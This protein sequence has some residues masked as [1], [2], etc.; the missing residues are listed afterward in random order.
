[1]INIA[2]LLARSS[3][4]PMPFAPR[5]ILAQNARTDLQTLARAHSTPQS[6]GLRARIVLKAADTDTPTNRQIGRDLG[7]S[8]HTVGKWRRRYLALGFSGLQDALRPGRPRTIASPTRVKVISVASELPQDQ[9]RTVTRWTLDEIVTTLLDALHTDAISRS[10]IWRI[11][12]DI[13]LKPHKSAYWLNS[14]DEHFD[15]KAHTICQL[16]AQALES[17][18][19]GRLVI[20]CDEKTGM[21]VLERKAPTKPAQPGR[22]ERREHEYI[23]HGTRVLINS[24]AVATGQLAWTMGATRKTTDFVVHLKQAYQSLPRMQCYDWVMD[25]LNTHW[26]LDVCCLV[27]RWCQV[28]FE[29]HKLKKGVQRRAFLSDPSHRHVFHFTPKHGS[30]LNQAELFFGVLH[31]RFLARGSFLSVKD[32]ERRLERFLQDYNARHAHPYRWTY[33]GEPLIRDTPFSRT[34]RQQ[35]HGRACFSPRPKRFARLFYAARPYRRQAA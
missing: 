32:F 7:C 15:A 22:R 33:T 25:N 24:L 13:D 27:A 35:R 2:G 12:H 10:S 17:Y 26:S 31:R 23:R 6:L 4:M 16:Y 20:C 9:E 5:I 34:R 8:N 28:P 3:P 19:R 29:P 14:H 30:W 21:Q 1:M 18:K 11:L